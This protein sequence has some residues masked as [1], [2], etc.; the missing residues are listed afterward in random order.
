[1]GGPPQTT[2]QY[3]VELELLSSSELVVLPPL[4]LLPLVKSTVKVVMASIVGGG[5][6]RCQRLEGRRDSAGGQLSF[7]DAAVGQYDAYI[8]RDA[9]VAR[10]Y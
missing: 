10:R 9:T 8:P 1:M 2:T 4:P 3:A 7:T 6:Q 5:R